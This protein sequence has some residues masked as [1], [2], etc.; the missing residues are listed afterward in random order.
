MA[1]G[2]ISFSSGLA[3][4]IDFGAIID[5]IIRAESAPIKTL[6][7]KIS[8]LRS[9]KSS[10]SSLSTLLNTFKSSLEALKGDSSVGGKKITVTGDTDSP[11]LTATATSSASEGNYEVAVSQIAQAHRVRSIGLDNRYSPLVT[12]GQITIQAE[13]YEE[14][15]IDV[16]A[17]HGNNSLSAVA[18]AINAADEGVQA[19]V[20][21]DGSQS[22]LVVKSK[23]TGTDHALTI[24]DTT[25]LNLDEGSNVLQAAQDALLEVDG[26]SITSSSNQ[27]TS[28]IAGV[29]LNLTK[30]TTGPVTIAVENDIEGTKEEIQNLV[31]SYNKINEFF[32]QHYGS[33]ASEG[34]SAIASSS[35]L[36]NVQ[37]RIQSLLT[38][39]ITGI[40][41]GKLSNLAVLGI[42]IAD[43]TGTLEFDEDKFDDLV[44]QGRFDEIRAV[45]LSSGGTTDNSVVFLGGTTN[46]QAGSYDIQVTQAAERATILGST[47]I[48]TGG[49][50]QAET[51]TFTMGEDSVEVDLA[52]NDTLD[53]I[54]SKI[55][56][57][58]QD[59]GMN[60]FAESNGGK[61]QLRSRDYGSENSFSVVSNV[62][63]PADG[64]T[65]GIGTTLL[66][67][68]GLDVV[69]TIN[70]VAAT[71]SGQVLTGA[72]GTDVAGI[73]VQVYATAE[74]VA[75]KGGDFGQVYYSQGSVDRFIEGIKDITD[76]Y[77]GLLQSIDESYDKSIEMANDKLTLLQER[78]DRREEL[79]TRQFSAAEQA[80]S[81]LNAMLAQLQSRS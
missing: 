9:A 41:S 33:A 45:L 39:S 14:I 47:A 53:M 50:A 79:L 34:S 10:F 15:T 57:A 38:G 20:V 32:Q 55:N 29:T 75:A 30:E 43:S 68:S 71:G 26:I 63:D 12:D 80:I 36:R 11:S 7:N 74:S 5:A 54:V 65:T 78:L 17:T 1:L 28:A 27:V 76:P 24:T 59:A 25:N 40:A 13:G 42:Q 21:N 70:G 4:G 49:I 19:S 3:S 8:T 81:Q 51:L 16:G 77:E 60:V 61:L 72:S 44:D 48:Q 6:E 64:T 66:E 62:A 46:T 52:Q 31:D 69:G 22:I 37:S 58:L 73:R 2:S 18:A 67:D 23:E 56:T 35:S